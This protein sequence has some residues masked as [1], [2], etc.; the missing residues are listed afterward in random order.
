MPDVDPTTEGAIVDGDAFVPTTRGIA[1]AASLTA[2]GQAALAATPTGAYATYL[3]DGS[4]RLFASTATK[5]YEALAGAWTDRSRVGNYTGTQRQRFCV[6]GNIVL[7]T[8][9]SEGIGQ[10]LSGAAFTDISGAPKASILVAAN[11]FVLA[12]DTTDATYGDRPDGWW[13]S[14]LRDQSTWTPSA[15]TQAE[16]ARLLDTPGKITAAAA[17]GNDVYAYK[18]TSL[19]RGRYM[20]P[21]LV[22]GWECVS[23]DVGTS[24]NESVV[25]VDGRQYFVGPNDFYVLDGQSGPQP[26]NAPCREWFFLNLHQ[27]YRSNIVAAVDIPRSLIYWYYP[28]TASTTGALDSVLIYNFRT[29][30]FGKQALATTM[31]VLYTSGAITY[32]S[33]GTLF[34]TYD[35]LPAIGYDSP[36]WTVD[37]TVP[38]VFV[39][40]ALYSV[41]GIPGTSWTQTG[42]FGDMTQYTF[43]S[44]AT[45]RYRTTPATGTAT[46]Y[47]RATLG[48]TLTADATATMSRSRFDFR[49]AARWHSVRINHTGSAVM[50]GLDVDLKASSAE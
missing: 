5:I 48:E 29:N 39:G 15:A 44:R 17:L 10:S 20:G 9:R 2:T 47:Y 13:C 40:T 21:P 50:D 23:T 43:M 18:A 11:G 8:N 6:F 14:G 32:D 25:T 31:P 35:D 22:W 41:T 27:T 19:Y 26:L 4:K 37:Q 49:R 24:G 34:A 16:N 12:F 42:D 45:P 30:Q 46:N 28:S 36:F 1:A 7:A 38:G 3:L 33:V